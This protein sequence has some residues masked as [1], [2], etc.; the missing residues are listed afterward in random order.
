MA[1]RRTLHLFL[2]LCASLIGSQI[3]IQSTEA[4]S[5]NFL[6]GS[7]SLRLLQGSWSAGRQEILISPFGIK[8]SN[9]ATQV[10]MI[11]PPPYSEV[12]A[13][14]SRTKR[15]FHVPLNK[16]VSPYATSMAT[17]KGVTFT[18]LK[19]NKMRALTYKGCSAEQWVLSKAASERQQALR[20]RGEIFRASPKTFEMLTSTKIPV[21]KQAIHFVCVY[22]AL[23]DATGLPLAAS[24]YNMINTH[25]HYLTTAKISAA[26]ATAKDYALPTNFK[27]ADSISDL[28][29]SGQSDDGMKLILMDH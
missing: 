16:F 29:L 6:D 11:L 10:V 8:I 15:L 22:Y 13:Y 9:P 4:T 19:L 28:V 21:N 17:I 18:E 1:W 24:Y 27:K 7:N 23:P 20:A 2:V 12:H 14:N 25:H 3:F 26:N 5:E